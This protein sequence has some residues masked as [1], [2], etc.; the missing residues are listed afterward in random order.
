MPDTHF[1]YQTV[2]SAE[3][4]DLVGRVFNNV[5][6]KYDIMNDIMSAGLHRLWKSTFINQLNP[7]NHSALL[8][9]AGG[10]GDIAFRF[11]KQAP[12][13]NVTIAD[14][15]PAML[16]EGKARQIDC[17]IKGNIRWVCA[18]AQSLAFTANQFDYYTIAFGI[19]N[20][21][22]IPLALKEAYRVLKPGGRFMC[23]EFSHISQPLLKQFY[24]FYSF[25]IIPNIGQYVANDKAAYQYL[26]ESIRMFPKAAE[27]KQ[28]I[29]EAGF[30]MVT[31]RTLTFGV[32]A[33]HSG[34]KI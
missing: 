33:I 15:N 8:D 24:D 3:K 23:L 27:F 16:C 5:A 30:R 6:P 32:V 20:V 13:A 7:S 11:L 1:G 19:R 21:T 4:S 17:Q 26:V 2:N 12:D 14:I 34:W 18:D 29:E 9:V 25:K 31:Y 10:T 22:D 28:F